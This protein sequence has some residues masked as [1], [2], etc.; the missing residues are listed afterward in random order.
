M[1][2]PL[3]AAAPFAWADAA[4]FAGP[5][6]DLVGGLFGGK[7]SGAA[8]E[9]RHIQW[10]TYQMQ[11]DLAYNGVARRVEDAKRAG[12]NPMVALGMNP[13][14]GGVASVVGDVGGGESK[15]G[16]LA[17]AGA[18][19]SRAIAARGTA[20]ERAAAKTLAGLA[21]EKAGLENDLLR[22]QIRTMEAQSAPAPVGSGN[23]EDVVM[24]DVRYPTQSRMPMGYG[25]TAPFWREG[26]DRNGRPVRVYNDELGDN[27]VL[28]AVTSPIAV[29]DMLRNHRRQI[30]R[31]QG[32][33]I[34]AFLKRRHSDVMHMIKS[35]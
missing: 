30:G 13:Y 22:S 12:V 33:S 28:Q 5:V 20:E 1:V 8:K 18:D 27:E 10:D 31:R 29:M 4:A 19:V 6:L 16:A 15:F 14:Q 34:G 7:S 11:K 21:L 3:A 32:E 23:Y 26:K 9:S 2:A 35:Y 25:D 17:K 24:K